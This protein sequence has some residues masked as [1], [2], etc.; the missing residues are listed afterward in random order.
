MNVARGSLAELEYY[1]ESS[2]DLR[3]VDDNSYGD[4]SAKLDETGRVLSG[5]FKS[6]Q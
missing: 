1:L 2:K 5:L 3:Y 6:Q 4:L